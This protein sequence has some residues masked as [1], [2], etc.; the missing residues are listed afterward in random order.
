MKGTLMAMLAVAL[1]ASQGIAEDL[2]HTVV[3]GVGG[4]LEAELAGGTVRGGSNW[5]SP[6]LVDTS[7]R[8]KV[9]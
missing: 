4:A 5:P 3:V 7:N 9:R 6:G 2:E 1:T 8:T